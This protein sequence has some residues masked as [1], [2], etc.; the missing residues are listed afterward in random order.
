MDPR[1]P[2]RIR[3]IA[4]SLDPDQSAPWSARRTLER[5]GDLVPEEVMA[6]LQLVATELVTNSIQ[7]S[8]ASRPGDIGLR[9]EMG[10]GMARIVVHDSGTG[11][12]PPHD[13]DPWRARHWGLHIVA[14]L[15]RRW[16]IEPSRR[17]TDVWAEFV[18]PA[19]EATETG[20]A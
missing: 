5:F 20:P 19:P 16:G 14:S 15:A 12:S 17:G 18:L 9:V 2:D 8:E 1:S 7:H 11:F 13:T 10:D 4:V 3:R 6:D